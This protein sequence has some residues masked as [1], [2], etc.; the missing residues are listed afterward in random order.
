MD[1]LESKKLAIIGGGHIGSALAQG[2][3]NSGNISASQL[4]VSNPTLPKIIH[5]KKHGVEVTSDNKFAVRK[6]DWVFLAV[7]PN[8]VGQALL[9]IKNE[10]KTKL[11]I[12]LAAV[13]TIDNLKKQARGSEVVRIMPNMAISCN[14]GVVGFFGKGQN[15][16]QIKQFLSLLGLV[17]EVKKESDLDILTLI[18]GCGPA[19]VSQFIEILANYGIRIGLSADISRILAL[20]TF[21]GTTAILEKL[22]LLP[23]ELMQSVSTKGGIS[24]RILNRLQESDFQ[25]SF[26]RAMASGHAKIKELSKTLNSEHKLTI[27]FGTEIGIKHL[28]TQLVNHYKKIGIG[29]KISNGSRQ[30]PSSADWPIYV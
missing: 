17:I 21:K 24:E 11:V 20:Q 18:S 30:F 16:K 6:A 23:S 14:Q 27:D 3:L 29:R 2:F 25:D 15:K 26:T 7:K 12:S 4:I 8:I 13:V 1:R 9:E 28:S 5:L 19:I 22:E 10:I